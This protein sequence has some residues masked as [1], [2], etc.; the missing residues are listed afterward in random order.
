MSEPCD[1]IRENL[2]RVREGISRAAQ[3]SGRAPEQVRL[4]AVTKY[5]D[6]PEIRALVDAGCTTLGESRPQQLWQR[7]ETFRDL[8]IQWHFIGHLQRNKAKRTLP[9]VAMIQSVDSLDLALVLERTAVEAG[10]RLPIL[11][12]VNVSG[13]RAKHGFAP[14]TLE[15]SL[16]QLAGCGHLEVCGLMCMAGLEG[17]GDRARADFSA[18]RELRDR[19]RCRCPESIRLDELSMGMSGD[20]EVA[21]EEGATIVRIGSALFE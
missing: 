18:L 10:R 6:E 15:S 17:G 12:E 8:P 9:L 3:R 4:V 19:L 21:I 11:V 5:V 14:E 7:A 13:E 20:Y 16:E 1:R 2:A